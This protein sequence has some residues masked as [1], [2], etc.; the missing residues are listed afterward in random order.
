MW[1]MLDCRHPE[2]QIWW[3][4]RGERHKRDLT[5]RDWT[6]MWLEGKLEHG[7]PGHLTMEDEESWRWP[8]TCRACLLT[9]GELQDPA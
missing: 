7:I 9:D 5:L 3:W 6:S 1:S 8:R 4:D 2:G